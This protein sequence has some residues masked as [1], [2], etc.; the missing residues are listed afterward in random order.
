VFDVDAHSDPAKFASE[1]MKRIEVTGE[2]VFDT[3]HRHRDGHLLE[4]RVRAR[5]LMLHG[6]PYFAAVWSDITESQRVA[7]ELEAHRK[8]LE[9]LVSER[10]GQIDALNRELAR[11]AHEAET[12]NSAKSTFLANMSHEIRTPMNA[13]VG[14][15]HLMRRDSHEATQ[16]ARLDRVSDAAHHLLDI[17][18]DILDFS[19]IEANK[20]VL[21]QVDFDLGALLQRACA[22]VSERADAKGLRLDVEPLPAGLKAHQFVGDPTRISQMLLNYLSNAVKFTETG[23]IVVSAELVTP[24]DDASQVRLCVR[25]TGI[26][27]DAVSQKRL[28]NAFEQADSSTT[29]RFGGTGLG[30]AI[31]KRLARLMGGSVGVDSRE[32]EG[33]TFWMTLCLPHSKVVAAAPATEVASTPDSLAGRR[34]LLAEDNPINQEVAVELL[35]DIGLEVVVAD[36][37]EQALQRF[38]SEPFDLILMDMQMPNMDGLEACR[39]IRALPNGADIPILAMTANAFAED[40]ERCMAAGMN[41]HI[42]KPVEPD[43]LYEAVEHWLR[44]V[45]KSEDA[46]GGATS[47]AAGAPVDARTVLDA[48][49]GLRNHGDKAARWEH[50]LRRFLRN[51]GDDLISIARLRMSGDLDTATQM[52]QLVVGAAETLGA[53]EVSHCAGTLANAL[54][55]GRTGEIE[56]A[57]TAMREAWMRLR[58]RVQ[59]LHETVDSR[60]SD[61]S[62][63]LL[64]TLAQLLD[65]DDFCATGFMTEHHGSLADAL[66]PATSSIERLVN[67]YDY[68]AALALLK[69]ATKTPRKAG[70]GST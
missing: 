2:T 10:T 61:S 66:G 16:L 68:P 22:M 8:H 45:A 35:S 48:D 17:I 58:E 56:A 33:S 67:D 55:E 51:H 4:V 21:E 15:T 43:V 62:E 23:H 36:D 54:A 70:A 12:A 65:N 13:I 49:T 37:G 38:G 14:I 41:A 19:K 29:R 59:H 53:G 24:G 44:P 30:L 57:S 26:G 50:Q 6:Q 5:A 46:N 27:I 11:R 25:D 47:S 64:R 63:Q 1:A 69:Q 32:G 20:L 42:S 31:N 40:R 52:A 60:A 18:N 28:F 7:R 34:V 9:A 3:Q 39:R